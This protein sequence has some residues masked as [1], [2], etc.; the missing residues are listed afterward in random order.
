MCKLLFETTT[1]SELDTQYLYIIY[2]FT[3][4]SQLQKKYLT[5][6]TLKQ[7]IHIFYFNTFWFAFL[8]HF[9]FSPSVWF[10]SRSFISHWWIWI[11]VT[12]FISSLITSLLIVDYSFFV[13]WKFFLWIFLRLKNFSHI[14]LFFYNFRFFCGFFSILFFSPFLLLSYFLCLPL[15]PPLHCISL[16]SHFLHHEKHLSWPIIY[17]SLTHF[18]VTLQGVS[19]NFSSL[20]ALNKRVVQR[21]RNTKLSFLRNYRFQKWRK[22][23]FLT[24]TLIIGDYRLLAFLKISYIFIYNSI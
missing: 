1:T 12:F 23:T 15:L 11:V 4:F 5:Y 6:S 17:F 2:Y 19:G 24:K 14:H 21:R 18:A 10:L 13:V 20:M 9:S 8:H 7:L 16:L 22:I 3:N